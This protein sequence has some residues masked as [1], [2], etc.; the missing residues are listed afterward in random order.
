MSF[1]YDRVFVVLDGDGK[2]DG[3]YK[4]RENAL[5]SL[6]DHRRN[7]PLE[8]A[9]GSWQ[10]GKIKPWVIVERKIRDSADILSL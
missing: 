6:S 1:S 3:I 9:D 4:K 5:N 8:M 7:T 10:Y 2:I